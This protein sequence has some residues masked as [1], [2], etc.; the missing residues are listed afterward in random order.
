MAKKQLVEFQL[1]G[2]KS[3]LVE[4]AEV[5]GSGIKPVSR[6]TG[7]L[8][9][10]AK[11]SFDEAIANLEPMISSIRKKIDDMNRPAEEVEVK[12]GV[13]L[14]GET[15]AVIATLGAEINYEITLKW[16]NKEKSE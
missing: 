8:A 6:K 2:D 15:S 5:E 4:V 7:E 3:I 11:Q 10:K 14:N 1:E 13:K 12:F 16:S 9:S